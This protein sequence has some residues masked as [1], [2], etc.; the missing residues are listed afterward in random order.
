MKENKNVEKAGGGK[1][2]HIPE[3]NFMGSESKRGEQE[4]KWGG[5]SD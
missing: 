3:M 5:R 2:E 4:R 1:H